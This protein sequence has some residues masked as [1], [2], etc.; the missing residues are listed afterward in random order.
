MGRRLLYRGR[1]RESWID[2]KNRFS[3]APGGEEMG[4]GGVGRLEAFP[5]DGEGVDV[6]VP[7][8]KGPGEVFGE[9]GDSM[10]SVAGR[11]F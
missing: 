9:E 1:L 10:G 11:L 2:G 5:W 7:F 3:L 4:G 6:V 8:G